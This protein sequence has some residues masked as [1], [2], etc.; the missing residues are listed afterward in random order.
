MNTIFSSPQ[1]SSTFS[2]KI[3]KP[4]SDS[5]T[6]ITMEQ[7]HSSNFFEV[8]IPHTQTV[9]NTDGVYTQLPNVTLSVK[10][11]DCLPVLIFHPK[12]L[13]AAV[14]AGRKSTRQ[15][16]IKKLL[17][18]LKNRH[19]IDDSLE[20]W[21]GPAICKDCYQI[22]REKNLHYDLLEKNTQQVRQVFSEE[23]AKIVYSNRCTAHENS[24]FYSYRKE[25]K[26]V[27][28]NWSRI[29]LTTTQA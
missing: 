16:I 22:D 23:Q 17:L 24:E 26:G 10:H 13:I 8:T 27:P 12:P 18:E 3:L 19:A 9:L 1:I 29:T 25:G 20:L 21:F 14:H 5:S 15:E 7:T 4:S 11:A 2:N 28:M 6:I